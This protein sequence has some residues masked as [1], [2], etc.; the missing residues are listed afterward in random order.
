MAHSST[1]F[2]R[3]YNPSTDLESALHVVRPP[4]CYLLLRTLFCHYRNLSYLGNEHILSSAKPPTLASDH[5]LQLSIS[6]PTYG[7]SHT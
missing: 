7:V 1:P 6:A 2:I 5:P 4:Y 3:Q